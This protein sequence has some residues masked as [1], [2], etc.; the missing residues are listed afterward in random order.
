[1]STVTA[2]VP[3]RLEHAGRL[4]VDNRRGTHAMLLT[5]ATE[6]AL[7]VMLF[8]AYFF[9]SK[10]GWRWP[11]EEPPKLKLALLMLAILLTSSGILTWGESQVKKRSYV[12]ARLAMAITAALGVIFLFVQ[13]LEYK[14]HL[15]TLTPRSNAY[16]SIFYT[17]TS[18]HAAHVVVGL[19][20]LLFVLA[21][22]RL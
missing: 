20:M 9:L 16:G 21:L 5:I 3:P 2:T 11:T 19:I 10:Q 1:M 14:D 12:A 7:F 22:P 13:Y 6:A 8:F 18:F 4:V 15:Q 17:I